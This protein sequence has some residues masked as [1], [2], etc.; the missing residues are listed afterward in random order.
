MSIYIEKFNNIDKMNHKN[1]YIIKNGAKNIL[2]IGG[3]RATLLAIYFEKVFSLIPYF[4]HQQ[5]GF[6]A[7]MV[8][9]L[10]LKGMSK[11]NNLVN[12]IENADIIICE[13]IKNFSFINTIK[14][15]EH[16]IFN[17]FNIKKDCQIVNIPNMELYFYESQLKLIENIDENNIK[18]VRE[19]HLNKLLHYCDY[20]NCY[21]LSQYIKDNI[22]KER[23]FATY[24]H[25]MSTL[26]VLL[27][28]DLFKQIFN[29]NLDEN[30]INIIKEI[31]IFDNDNNNFSKISELDYNTGVDRSVT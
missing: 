1:T 9:I 2:F 18:E 14:T 19:I 27:T 24:N 15:C 30:V 8:H 12:A 17:N 21:E 16:N 22:Y 11:T 6:G 23:L 13:Q 26:F 7:I 5:F 20:F 25:P 10:N 29:Y 28:K 31:K 3:C 4:Y